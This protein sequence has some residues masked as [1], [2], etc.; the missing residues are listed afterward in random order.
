MDEFKDQQQSFRERANEQYILG[1][2]SFERMKQ[3]QNEILSVSDDTFSW[4]FNDEAEDGDASV[5]S[6][7]EYAVMFKDWLR[8]G[9]GIFH[10]SGK[11]GSG[12]SALMKQIV[13]HRTTRSMLGDW[14]GS[15]ALA[16]GS[17]FF[18]KPGTKEQRNTAGLLRSLLY[19][20]LG[21][22]PALIP[23][24]FPSLWEPGQHSVWAAKQPLDIFDSEIK[25]V[26]R[27]LTDAGTLLEFDLRICFFIDGLDE[28][29]DDHEIHL[30]LVDMLNDWV[31]V[32][33]GRVKLCVSS[34][35]LPVFQKRLVTSHRIRMQDVNRQDIS[36]YVI[37]RL[38]RQTRDVSCLSDPGI[39]S[40]YDE[41]MRRSDGI[42]LWTTLVM[43]Q[44][45]NMSLRPGGPVGH[46]LN[47]VR[48]LPREFRDLVCNLLK[49][50]PEFERRTVAACFLHANFASSDDIALLGVNLLVQYSETILLYHFLRLVVGNSDPNSS[51]T[52]CFDAK[53]PVLINDQSLREALQSTRDWIMGD[54]KGLLEVMDPLRDSSDTSLSL[55]QEA[56]SSIARF[57]HRAVREYVIEHVTRTWGHHCNTSDA[58][59]YFVK[60]AIC[61]CHFLP[62]QQ[63]QSHKPRVSLP[64]I[65]ELTV[66]QPSF[67]DLLVELTLLIPDAH[68]SDNTEYDS[69]NCAVYAAYYASFQLCHRLVQA[70]PLKGEDRSA[71]FSVVLSQMVYHTAPVFHAKDKH[72]TIAKYIE[73]VW[74]LLQLLFEGDIDLFIRVGRPFLEQS[75]WVRVICMCSH[76][77]ETSPTTTVDF[78]WGALQLFLEHSRVLPSFSIIV[79]EDNS[80]RAF[81]LLFGDRRQRFKYSPYAS[82]LNESH[83]FFASFETTATLAD[84]VRFCHPPN[85]GVLLTMIQK[86]EATTEAVCSDAAKGPLAV[87]VEAQNGTASVGKQ[88]KPATDKSAVEARAGSPVSEERVTTPGFATNT[89][90][91]P[92]VG[93]SALYMISA[94]VCLLCLYIMA[95]LPAVW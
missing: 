64:I 26:F 47:A 88:N 45:G 2:I 87:G 60:S 66:Y 56:S 1:A 37:D 85:E 62:L 32:S 83:P 18:W 9:N 61:L 89:A 30:D 36:A 24:L 20:I 27:I 70:I 35:E 22:H 79:D 77:D 53:K 12:K 21:Q 40:L 16:F 48:S 54:C 29:D 75:P 46:V 28:F 82:S 95:W 72:E 10:V 86:I 31:R 43:K 42:I 57:T 19:D 49:S 11:L 25:R 94:L 44:V 67:V 3:R 84:F 13:H 68:V 91:S 78:V 52:E 76:L 90:L 80:G 8:S 93:V 14:A 92:L 69:M 23:F 51:G 5:S 65:A 33:G 41:I 17:C 71:C 4:I 6:K 34:R 58:E 74:P 73:H 7:L 63:I 81:R 15:N 55:L 38:Q 50:I 59:V 39:K